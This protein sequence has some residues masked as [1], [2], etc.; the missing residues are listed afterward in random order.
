MSHAWQSLTV[1]ASSVQ[2]VPFIQGPR[3]CLGQFF[4]LLEGRV[5]LALLVKV[6]P[7][8]VAQ[9]ITICETPTTLPC[10]RLWPHAGSPG[11]A[12]SEGHGH[13]GCLTHPAPSCWHYSCASDRCLIRVPCSGSSSASGDRMA[14]TNGCRRSYRRFR[15]TASASWWTNVFT[16]EHLWLRSGLFR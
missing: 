1:A 14:P 11:H 15:C 13:S 4:A 3:N 5:V 10:V 7:C 2:F 9:N 16:I 12:D 8:P 6:R